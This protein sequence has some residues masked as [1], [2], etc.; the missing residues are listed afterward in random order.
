[1]PGRGGFL[2]F[3]GLVYFFPGVPWWLGVMVFGVA[4]CYL[5]LPGLGYTLPKKIKIKTI[6]PGGRPSGGW[7]AG[8]VI[9]NPGARALADS[10]QSSFPPRRDNDC[11]L[12]GGT[13]AW[14][15][16]FAQFQLFSLSSSPSNPCKTHAH[17]TYTNL[18]HARNTTDDR[19]L[20]AFLGNS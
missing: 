10:H 16:D 7:G 8:G 3:V 4:S 20:L 11:R 13:K 14:L 2:G 18:R 12:V 6:G 15:G 17:S 1:M 19:V 9:L 5:Q